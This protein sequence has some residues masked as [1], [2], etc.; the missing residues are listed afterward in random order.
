[1]V[2]STSSFLDIPRDTVPSRAGNLDFDARV[3]IPFSIFPSTYRN[4]AAAPTKVKE[5]HVE[6]EIKLPALNQSSSGRD[7][8]QSS[9]T[10][11]LPPQ[12]QEQRTEEKVHINVKEDRH[13]RPSLFRRPI[14]EHSTTHIDVDLPHRHQEQS[15]QFQQPL[16]LYHSDN[17]LNSTIDIAERQY[18]T[19]YQP[20]FQERVSIESSVKPSKVIIN[21]NMG[22]YDEAGHYHS[23]RNG[24][25]HAAD[26]IV[27]GSH[28]HHH[29]EIDVEIT[30]TTSGG[31]SQAPRSQSL[32][33]GGIPNT[34]TIPTNHVRIGD[35][36]ILQGR[37]SQVIKITTSPAT[38]QHRFLGVDLFTKQL[39]EDSSFISSPSP[40]VVVQTVLGPVLKQ[41]RVLDLNDG[42]VVAMTE[43]G[44]VKQSLPVIDQS[45]LWV[46]LNDAFESGRG[47]VRV[48]V[49]ND[50]GRELAVD[51]KVIHGS[52]L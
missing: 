40:S 24:L 3:P 46:R 39:H 51:M 16:N 47:S 14:Q 13:H 11:S 22:Y 4:V 1:M 7:G 25:H 32:Q 23:F 45:N 35:I 52:R 42:T 15:Q 30:S 9:F 41:Y 48:L 6:G 8:H 26:R 21:D 12:E 28:H 50:H 27:N 20:N 31:S 44:D 37:A 5:T 34:I 36:V 18:R 38:G 19:R 43:T 33:G 10:A 17:N 49:L 29:P 2:T